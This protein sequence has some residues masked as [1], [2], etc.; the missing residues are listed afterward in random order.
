MARITSRQARE[1]NEAYAKVHQ[2]LQEKLTR[3]NPDDY[4]FSKPMGGLKQ[5]DY[6][7]LSGYHKKN[8]NRYTTKAQNEKSL[9]DAG[10]KKD[11]TSIEVTNLT[12]DGTAKKVDNQTTEKPAAQNNQT[13]EKPAAQNNQTT[14]KPASGGLKTLSGN[15]SKLSPDAQKKVLA[16]KNAGNNNQS[17]GGSTGGGSGSYK[18]KPGEAKALG[19]KLRSQSG[20][21]V[22]SSDGQQPTQEPGVKTSQTVVKDGNRTTT[23]TRRSADS[24]T[25]EGAAAVEK[26]KAARADRM[27]SRRAA[28]DGNA[29]SG[30]QPPSTQGGGQPPAQG[31]AQK[32]GLLGRLGSLAGKAV[33][34]ARSA[35]G[36]VKQGVQS[37]ASN[38]KQGVQSAASN[39]KQ[40]AQ[41]VAGA[42][43]NKGPIQGR[44]T[45][46]QRRAQQT[47]ARP[48]PTAQPAA[49]PQPTAQPAA[50]PVQA[51][52][53]AKPVP[54]AQPVAKPAA[55]QLSGAQRAQQMA[56]QRIAQGRNTVTGALKS[57]PAPQAKRP[58]KGGITQSWQW[59][60][61]DPV[62]DDT[63]Q[64]LV[65]EGH[66]KD[67]SEAVSI[68]SESE[69]IDAFNQEING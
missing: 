65:S 29:G 6:D 50:R 64:F 34:A 9:S 7:A 20:D 44:Q 58:G 30:G 69:F 46:A 42:L 48:Q 45:G 3:F 21:K 2:N 37:A 68:M 10:G 38:V 22:Q 11:G 35:A 19:D 5:A 24:S 62:F 18:F 23:T 66:A 17:S 12:K 55:P 25:P 57:K 63:V 43:A 15:D 32:P 60:S 33:G 13:T 56:K 61:Y 49:R 36:N 41:A 52:P 1:M 39:V 14:E 53:V 28:R 4:D 59:D 51:A 54:Q 40:G 16:M 31:G 26:E 67:K 47:A 8:I 27:A